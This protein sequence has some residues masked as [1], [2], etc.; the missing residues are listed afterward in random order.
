MIS[1][2]CSPS[3]SIIYSTYGH[4]LSPEEFH[5]VIVKPHSVSYYLTSQIY[6]SADPD[7]ELPF[8]A[9][10]IG[11]HMFTLPS[12]QCSSIALITLDLT[13]IILSSPFSKEGGQNSEEDEQDIPIERTVCDQIRSTHVIPSRYSPLFASSNNQLFISVYPNSLCVITFSDVS[14]SVVLEKNEIHFQKFLPRFLYG[15]SISQKVYSYDTVDD[16]IKTIDIEKVPAAL[17][18]QSYDSSSLLFTEQISIQKDQNEADF[19]VNFFIVQNNQFLVFTE[20][21]LINQSTGERH[22]LPNNAGVVSVSLE[23]ENHLLISFKNGDF[24]GF[25]QISKQF[26]E[27]GNMKPFTSI[28][29]IDEGDVML[30]SKNEQPLIFSTTQK[31]EK[32]TFSNLMVNSLSLI[33]VPHSVPGLDQL[34]ASNG[35]EVVSYGAGYPFNSSTITAFNG[36][37]LFMIDDVI[38]ASNHNQTVVLNRINGEDASSENPSFETNDTTLGFFKIVEESSFWFVQCCS[39][40]IVAVKNDDKNSAVSFDIEIQ[41]ATFCEHSNSIVV[42]S[43]SLSVVKFDGKSFSVSLN[44]E[45]NDEI[46]SICVCKEKFLIVSLWKNLAV[47]VFDLD[48]GQKLSEFAF[49]QS[50]TKF[51]VRSICESQGFVFFGTSRGEIICTNLNENS[52]ELVEVCHSRVSTSTINLASIELEGSQFVCVS[53]DTTSL[54][55]VSSENSFVVYPTNLGPTRVV[56]QSNS[57]EDENRVA[58]LSESNVQLGDFG[59]KRIIRINKKKLS[60]RVLKLLSIDESFSAALLKNELV[61]ID[62]RL[63]F[64]VVGNVPLSEDYNY[65]NCASFVVDESDETIVAIC[66]GL[67]TIEKDKFSEN[68]RI[69][70]VRNFNEIVENSTIQTKG[71]PTAVTFVNGSLFVAAGPTIKRYNASKDLQFTLAKEAPGMMLASEL[72]VSKPIGSEK[73]GDFF[74]VSIV[75]AFKSVAVFDF[76]LHRIATDFLAKYLVAGCNETSLNDDRSSFIVSDSKGGVYLMKVEG[77]RVVVE[78]RMSFGEAVTG[79][80]RWKPIDLSF[81][82]ENSIFDSAFCGTT[83]LGSIVAFFTRVNPK[84]FNAMKKLQTAMERFLIQNGELSHA[85]YRSIYSPAYRE[86]YIEYVDANFVAG[87]LDFEE[88]DR[89]KILADNGIDDF[90][91]IH[92]FLGSL[93]EFNI[94]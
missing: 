89:N 28:V 65:T 20:S 76:E 52:G 34:L 80:S 92:E 19:S 93:E 25:D 73:V 18:E 31:I 71:L 59:N 87:I 39:K 26:I 72:I 37:R 27:Y 41:H 67:K 70:F 82:H 22:A 64:E 10:I 75:D 5:L 30:F 56:I 85:D 13:L 68:G 3:G 21:E 1:Y 4:F 43:N 24:Y 15:D 7:V 45:I 54:V 55:S 57:S 35:E 50:A 69:F 17:E 83:A 40:K 29:P 8:E 66:A 94:Q 44:I 6:D 90:E 46:S 38:L 51:V 32:F 79:I 12:R 23:G 74:N 53:S 11:A 91:A 88:E 81:D 58:V 84:L 16:T 61:V 86:P 2:T 47:F 77:D 14:S 42:A 9:T 63:P 62:H 78:S 48:N 33:T 36:G 49:S 60:S